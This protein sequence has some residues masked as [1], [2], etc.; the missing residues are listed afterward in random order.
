MIISQRELRSHIPNLGTDQ[1]QVEGG[2]TDS[3]AH[4]DD[5]DIVSSFISATKFKGAAVILLGSLNDPCCRP[6]SAQGVIISEAALPT[7]R[8]REVGVDVPFARVPFG[9]LKLLVLFGLGLDPY[10]ASF[11][12]RRRSCIFF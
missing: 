2:D 3:E 12:V 1:L 8:R 9:L 5:T 4:I 6:E 11:S 10:M 7:D